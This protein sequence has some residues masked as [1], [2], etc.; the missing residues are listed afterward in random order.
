MCVATIAIYGRESIEDVLHYLCVKMVY[1][2]TVYIAVC[3]FKNVAVF[4]TS[5]AL[6]ATRW[7]AVVIFEYSELFVYLLFI[8]LSILL[9]EAAPKATSP[10][11]PMDTS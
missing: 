9:Q 8:Y 10:N 6:Q 2:L 7:C 1:P 4:H 11:E 3:A 5:F